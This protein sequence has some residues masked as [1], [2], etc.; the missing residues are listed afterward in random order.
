[1]RCAGLRRE[2]AE[3]ARNVRYHLQS[4]LRGL[5]AQYLEPRC[6]QYQV[7]AGGTA[8]RA[9]AGLVQCCLSLSYFVRSQPGHQ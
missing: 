1:M 3:L 6:M 5:G 4:T 8:R 7:G 9:S 2:E